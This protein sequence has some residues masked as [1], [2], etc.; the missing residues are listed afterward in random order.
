MSDPHDETIAAYDSAADSWVD[1][2]EPDLPAALGFARWVSTVT[3]V[4]RHRIVDLGC[5][6]GWHLDRLAA[7]ASGH[8]MVEYR[9][10]GRPGAVGMDASISMLGHAAQR[11]SGSP[12]VQGDLRALPFAAGS[13]DGA[14]VERS[15][16]HLDR[17][18]L[19][20]ALWDI[21]RILGVGAGLHLGLF[22][23]D[24]EHGTIDGDDTPGR[25]F[26]AWPEPLLRVVLEGA[27]FRLEVMERSDA[28]AVGRFTIRARRERTLAD[29]VGPGMRLLLVGLN[30][31]FVAADAGVGFHRSGNRAWP[32]LLASGLATRDRDPLHL[33][34]A[35]RVGMTDLVKTPSARAGILTATQFDHGITRLERLCTWLRPS[36]VCLLGVSG[37]RQAVDRKATVGVQDRLLGGRPVYL[38]PNPSGANAH[39]TL[40]E[41]VGHLRSA[42]ELADDTAVR[43]DSPSATA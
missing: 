32:A 9:D 2:R 20:L 40:D 43:T 37:W 24:L 27:G 36:A 34:T 38:M 5:G 3:S 15:L 7:A 21:H 6:P 8:D 10:A 31:S 30:P 28:G 12:L 4:D 14:W 35:H 17:H 25:W 22:E 16:V 19:P 29:T 23:G 13:F 39:V 41:L 1:R 26:S 11:S 42:A 18:L 33:L